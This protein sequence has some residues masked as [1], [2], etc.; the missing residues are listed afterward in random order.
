[1]WNNPLANGEGKGYKKSMTRE[2]RRARPAHHIVYEYANLVSAGKIRLAGH[3]QQVP[4]IP[5]LN[6]HVWHAFYTYCRS[7]FEFFR[8]PPERKYLRASQFVQPNSEFVFRHWTQRVQ[9]HMEVHLMHVGD[10]RTT[11]RKAWTGVSVRP[12]PS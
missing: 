1:M 5:P 7:M 10:D 11:G 8:Y 2:E 9:T 3:Y 4:L 12:T 6:S